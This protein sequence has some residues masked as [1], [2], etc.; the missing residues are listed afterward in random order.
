GGGPGRRHL[1]AMRIARHRA[2]LGLR[3][4]QLQGAVPLPRLPG[5]VRILQG[6]LDM[7]ST[8]L[9]AGAAPAASGPS[10]PLLPRRRL[11]FHPLTV[12]AI[13]RLTTDAVEV[14]FAVPDELAG[15]FDY[16]P[17]QHVAVRI[18][19]EGRE[20]RRSYSLCAPA[21]GGELHIAVKAE[22]GGIFS[23]FATS[24]LAIG[25]TVE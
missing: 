5:A 14:V 23:T 7:T 21:G 4:H 17:G 8:T 25:D 10:A 2:A 9:P 22:P 20:I 16:L 11:A 19:H 3:R 6:A 18:Q 13:H 12:S 1:P 24:E 15:E